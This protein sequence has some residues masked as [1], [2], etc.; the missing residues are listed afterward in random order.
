[1]MRSW[2][3]TFKKEKNL[4]MTTY[5]SQVKV[6]LRTREN[7]TISKVVRNERDVNNFA[8][9]ALQKTSNNH[10]NK[11]TNKNI[12]SSSK[13]YSMIRLTKLHPN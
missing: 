11:M 13:N 12:K 4:V 1:M 7:K 5:N 3:I 10:G 8:K 2:K 9:I 6:F